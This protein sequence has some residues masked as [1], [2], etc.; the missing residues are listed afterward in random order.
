MTL[1]WSAKMGDRTGRNVRPDRE[2]TPSRGFRVPTVQKL[3]SLLELFIPDAVDRNNTCSHRRLQD[4]ARHLGWDDGTTHRFLVSLTEIGL[5]E[6][7]IDDRFSLGIFAVQL[8]S[9]Y[10]A[11][12]RRRGTIIEKMEELG[13]RTRLTVEIGALH[14]GAMVVIA[15]KHGSTPLMS[16][17]MLGER[18]PLHA[19][20]GGKAILS[21]LADVVVEE[22]CRGKLASLASNTRTAMPSLM[23]DIHGIRANGLSRTLSE[24]AEGLCSV[25]IP[26]P[27]GCFGNCPAALACSGPAALPESGWEIAEEGLRDIAACLHDGAAAADGAE[28]HEETIRDMYGPALREA[29]S[30]VRRAPHSRMGSRGA[31]GES[32]I[33]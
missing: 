12:D 24:Y 19:T 26:L 15:S 33:S 7:S 2:G 22:L 29:S 27:R 6:R 32:E 20:A 13:V 10:I 11:T 30:G 28:A 14:G 18:V 5:L 9:V 21:Q 23:Q 8:A 1:I 4:I 3:G 31:G 25:A 17:S 16:R